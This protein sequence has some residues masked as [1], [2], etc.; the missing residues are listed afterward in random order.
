MGGPSFDIPNQKPYPLQPQFLGDAPGPGLTIGSEGIAI[1]FADSDLTH[2][3]ESLAALQMRSSPRNID[4]SRFPNAAQRA[5]IASYRTK[6]AIL[7]DIEGQFEEHHRQMTELRSLRDRNI[8]EI[9]DLSDALT[10]LDFDEV[11]G[12]DLYGE[13]IVDNTEEEAGQ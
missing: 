7:E 1:A 12:L 6:K 4:S 3:A 8:K 10:D 13:P 2:A 11:E 9:A 5:L